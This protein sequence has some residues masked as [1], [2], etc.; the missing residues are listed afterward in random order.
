M[1]Q[2]QLVSFLTTWAIISGGA[3]LVIVWS[4]NPLSRSVLLPSATLGL[5]AASKQ[6]LSMGGY[7]ALKQILKTSTTPTDPPKL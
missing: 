1:K 7:E 6:F 4:G 5:V 3:V 2:F